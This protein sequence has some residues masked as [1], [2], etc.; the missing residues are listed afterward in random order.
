MENFTLQVVVS[1]KVIF[2][3]T[4]KMEK[5][6]KFGNLVL[7]MLV[8]GKMI[9][10]MAKENIIIIMEIILKEYFKKINSLKELLYLLMEIS[11]KVI[12]TKMKTF[13]MEHTVIIMVT[14]I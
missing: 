10:C 5:E 7:N 6:H 11:S 2:L 12:L 14:I 3:M 1:M 8:N 4:N 13:A 9:K